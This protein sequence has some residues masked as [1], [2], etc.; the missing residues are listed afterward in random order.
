MQLA[1]LVRKMKL[2]IILLFDSVLENCLLMGGWGGC[3]CSLMMMAEVC[4]WPWG[5]LIW[6]DIGFDFFF[7]LFFQ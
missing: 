5:A 4:V 7:S 6:E 1:L 2:V 3:T